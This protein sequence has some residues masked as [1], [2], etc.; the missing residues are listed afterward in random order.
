MGSQRSEVVVWAEG[1]SGVGARPC[2]HIVMGGL[3]ALVPVGA[4]VG[5]LG[6]SGSAGCGIGDSLEAFF[7]AAA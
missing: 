2:D 6:T 5:V 7:T 1:N 4:L 3:R